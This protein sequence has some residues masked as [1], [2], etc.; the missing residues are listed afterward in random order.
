MSYLESLKIF[1][2]D[3][4]KKHIEG[5]RNQKQP[6]NKLMFNT[7]IDL[8]KYNNYKSKKISKSKSSS[9]VVKKRKNSEKKKHIFIPINLKGPLIK[10]NNTKK[11]ITYNKSTSELLNDPY[12]NINNKDH[13]NKN[14][15]NSQ[16]NTINYIINNFNMSTKKDPFL[17]KKISDFKGKSQSIISNNN[18]INNK[19]NNNNTN[20]NNKNNN[21]NNNNNNLKYEELKK[22]NEKLI[23]L[24]N[25]KIKDNKKYKNKVS[26]LENKNDQIL[27]KINKIKKENEKYSKILE[28][29]L[30]LLQILKSNGLDVE[31]I[32]ENL[33]CTDEEDS[34]NSSNSDDISSIHS[35]NI[36]DNNSEI[37]SDISHFKSEG[38]SIPS[39]NIKT[40][41]IYKESKVT[42]KEN[43]IPKLDMKKIYNNNAIHIQKFETNNTNKHKNY[44]HSVGK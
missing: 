23:L 32:L 7:I 37:N 43:N 13:T 16:F 31:E 3:I 44:A 8:E 21:C 5:R 34:N 6:K 10:T 42:L 35:K 30:K 25:E 36:S 19:S 9:T 18:N 1:N 11:K 15:K 38:E 12:K 40:N 2:K 17:H 24:F 27:K 14:N 29:V 20:S 28:K 4:H 39:E 41:K 26:Y 22:E 33:S